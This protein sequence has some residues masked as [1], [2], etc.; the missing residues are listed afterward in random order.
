M[1]N[2]KLLPNLKSRAAVAVLGVHRCSAPRAHVIAFALRLQIDHSCTSKAV[3]PLR[4]F[5]LAAQPLLAKA[6]RSASTEPDWKP[7]AAGSSKGT[8]AENFTVL[9][10]LESRRAADAPSFGVLEAS[11]PLGMSRA[12]LLGLGEP[13]ILA[14]NSRWSFPAVPDTESLRELTA[15]DSV[16][17]TTLARLVLFRALCSFSLSLSSRTSSSSSCVSLTNLSS[18]CVFTCSAFSKSCEI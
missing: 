13:S 14:K 4:K 7:A 9:D 18:R 12:S 2:Y 11:L 1:E 10:T 6:L 8:S 3:R 16:L 5:A 17:E 15:G